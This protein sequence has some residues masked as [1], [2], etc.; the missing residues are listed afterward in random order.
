VAASDSDSAPAWS[1]DGRKIVFTCSSSQ[2]SDICVV[3]ANGSGRLR[4]TE[5][6]VQN[7]DPSWQ[8]V[9]GVIPTGGDGRAGLK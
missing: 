2:I 8:P 6:G 7:L 9:R 1:P 5:D 4:L 3:N